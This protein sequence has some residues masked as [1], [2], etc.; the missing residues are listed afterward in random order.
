MGR[1]I[2]KAPKN[3]VLEISSTIVG[4]AKSITVEESTSKR[5]C[6]SREKLRED[7]RMVFME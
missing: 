2:K 1:E 5:G 6:S 3:G 7:C 4:D